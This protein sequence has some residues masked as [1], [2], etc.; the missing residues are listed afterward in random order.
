MAT[1]LRALLQRNKGRDLFDLAHALDVFDGFNATRVVDC[2]GLYLQRAKLQVSRAEAENRMFAKLA[3]PAFLT[4]MR[5]LLPADQAEKLNET[6]TKAAFAKV[7]THFIVQIPGEPW[8]K[9]EAMKQRFGLQ[10]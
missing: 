2:F 10:G 1:K 8:A 3:N 5:P 4:D 9:T 7:Y 6:S